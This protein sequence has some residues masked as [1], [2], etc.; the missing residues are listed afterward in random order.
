MAIFIRQISMKLYKKIETIL[1][2]LK[3][4]GFGHLVGSNVINKIL[5]FACSFL[6]V[7]IIPK[8]EYGIYA[9]ADNI[10]GMFCLLEGFGMTS[11]FLQFGCTSKG[12]KKQAIWSYCFSIAVLFQFAV[13]LLVLLTSIFAPIKIAGTN[14]LLALMAFLPLPRAIRD[15]QQVYLRTELK[16]KEYA[17]SNTFSTV[18]SVCLSCLL[19]V[20]FHAKGLIAAG[21]IS[22]IAT[23]VFILIKGKAKFPV[24]KQGSNVEKNERNRILKFSVVCIINNSTSSLMYLLDTFILGLVVADGVVTA[25][26]KV[27]SKIPT[28]L[29]FIP[30]CLMVYIYPYFAMHKDDG[31][32]CLE[33]YKKVVVSFG[34]FNLAMVVLLIAFAPQIVGLIF[35]VQ[36]LD[37]VIPFRVL[38]INYFI[39][40]TFSTISG[41]LIVSQEKLIYN[42]FIGILSGVLNTVMNLLFIPCYFSAGAAIAT[43]ITT[44]FTG[45]VSTTYL[46]KLFKEK[47]KCDIQ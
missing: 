34:M 44:T 40:A 8:Q 30:T 46:L 22:T 42:T 28:A 15:M 17:Y 26:Y 12:K 9:N 2:K 43:V 47:K 4:T 23:I 19:S 39:Q 18:V 1:K 11:T 10:L 45:I 37:A 13:C 41:Q 24:P 3:E 16:N 6:L 20:F 38:C 25:S 35:G 21:Y 5:S 14:A 33:K 7:R 32:W 31:K 29:A 27:A 36:Y